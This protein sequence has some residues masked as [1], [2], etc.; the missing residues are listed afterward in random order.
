MTSR[1]PDTL[2][3]LDRLRIAGLGLNTPVTSCRRARRVAE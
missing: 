1:M 2:I 3:W